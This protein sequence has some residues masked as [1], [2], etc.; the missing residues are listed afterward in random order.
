MA[1]VSK[2]SLA[3]TNRDATPRVLNGAYLEGGM[4]RECAGQAF[5]TTGDNSPSTYKFCSVPSN[6]RVSSIKIFW[7]GT[8]G[9]TTAAHFGVWSV[10]QQGGG[11][12]NNALFAT[13]VSMSAAIV[14][15]DVVHEAAV[16]GTSAVN[17]MEK[18]LWEVLGLASDPGT[19]YDIGAILANTA[20]NSGSLGA[21]VRYSI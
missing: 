18:R 9:T 4:V 6:A 13:A 7:E 21:L 20:D 11:A 3:L 10:T 2:L 17:G 12:I 1:T 14:G 19:H 5:V 16:S 15:T 8:G